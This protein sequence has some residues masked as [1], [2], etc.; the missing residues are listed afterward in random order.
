MSTKRMLIKPVYLLRTCVFSEVIPKVKKC[1]VSMS[2]ACAGNALYPTILQGT[3]EG[4]KACNM[5][6]DKGNHIF[7]YTYQGHQT[8]GCP[9]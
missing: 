6:D 2:S 5:R 7:N 4:E 8:G 3:E 1:L 9:W